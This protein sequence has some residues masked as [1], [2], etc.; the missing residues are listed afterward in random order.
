MLRTPSVTTGMIRLLR[1]LRE[2]HRPCLNKLWFFSLNYNVV[3]L[4]LGIY[5]GILKLS[6]PV[7][8]NWGTE[9]E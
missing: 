6:Y 7:V 9:C 3:K 4:D 2:Q 5:K 1:K 8:L